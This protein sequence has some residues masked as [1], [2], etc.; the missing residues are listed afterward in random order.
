MLGSVPNSML[1]FVNSQEKRHIA[2]VRIL[3]AFSGGVEGRFRQYQEHI[4]IYVS[5]A[6]E[7]STLLVPKL[8]R[9]KDGVGTTT[10]GATVH[11]LVN[12]RFP[13]KQKSIH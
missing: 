3:S 10:C 12:T 7:A 11:A 5:L 4:L 2:G 9:L 6:L 1:V 8:Q 13:D